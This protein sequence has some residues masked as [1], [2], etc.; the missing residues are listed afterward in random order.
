MGNYHLVKFAI[1]L[2]IVWSRRV[3][4]MV[5]GI[6]RTAAGLILVA[7]IQRVCPVVWLVLLCLK[8]SQV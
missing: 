6:F 3:D 1:I 4:Q 5:E 7:L 2:Q 8:A